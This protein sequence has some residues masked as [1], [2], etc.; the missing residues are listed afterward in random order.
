[1]ILL[2]SNLIK[3]SVVGI[4]TGSVIGTIHRAIIDPA[5]LNI[6]AYEVIGPLVTVRPTYLLAR[7]IRELSDMGAIIDS[8]DEFIIAGDVI[9]LDKLEA[10]R[11]NPVSMRVQDEKGKKL[12][13]VADF[14]IDMGSYYIQQLVVKRPL[15]N[16]LGDTELLVHRTQIIEINND[17]IVVHSQAAAFEPERNQVVGSYINPFRKPGESVPEQSTSTAHGPSH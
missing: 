3:S 16:S 8:V 11:F 1:M 9:A 12:G 6:F 5:K 17:A 15:M 13:K 2:G 7:D 4:Q 10:L 14:T